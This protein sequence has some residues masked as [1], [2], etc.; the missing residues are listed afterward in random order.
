M[1]LN[2]INSLSHTKQNCKHHIVFAAKYR[3]KVLFGEKR[4]EIGK[5]LRQLCEWKKVTIIE[6]EVCPNHIHILL[7]IPSK[8]AVSS[9][10]GYQKGKSSLLIYEQFS[11]V[12]YKD[13]NRD[14]GWD[15]KKHVTVIR[16]Y[17]CLYNRHL[18]PFAQLLQDF[19]YLSALF[20]KEY[21]APIFRREHHVIF[22]IPLRVR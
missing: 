18:F 11:K 20:A 3:C 5:I 1:S 7:E 6:T 21:F 9:F 8:I 16:T 4:R 2:D 22:A 15:L 13:R 19:S 17:F 12:K 14:V 10:V